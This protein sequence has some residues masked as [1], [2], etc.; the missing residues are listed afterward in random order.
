MVAV[1]VADCGKPVAWLSLDRDDNEAG[2]F[3]TYLIAALQGV[4]GGIGSEA[5]Q[6]LAGAQQAS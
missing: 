2:R 4:D 6:L 3:L 5:A 1:C